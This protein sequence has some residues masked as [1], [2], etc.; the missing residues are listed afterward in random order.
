[1]APA[2][3]PPALE[4]RGLARHVRPGL[5]ARS[6]P[7]LA[8]L[9]LVLEPGATLGLIG[10]NGSGKSTLLRIA[11]GV[12]RASAGSVRLFGLGPEDAAAR[13][14]VG[15]LPEG[16]PFPL[17]LSARSVLLLLCHFH[18][19]PRA[20]RASAADEW[21]ERVGLAA[22]AR[23]HLA[24]FSLGM[25]RRFGLA[26]ACM[27]APELL[28]LDEPT[29]GLDAPGH[30]VLEELLGE[31]RVRGAALLFATHVVSDLEQHC[32]RAAVLVG[33][34]LAAVGPT[35]DL[36]N[37]ARLLELYRGPGELGSAR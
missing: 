3:S 34:R 27:H 9:D 23:R 19:W 35:Q 2:T 13:R 8:G 18:G 11:A 33:G 22:D 31:A 15:F 17:E 20:R 28:L 30:L 24:H 1:M 7:I 36:G 14:R 5:F 4:I 37:R 21:L 6:R 10:P 12:E 25:R 16:F 29:A 32:E 26:Q